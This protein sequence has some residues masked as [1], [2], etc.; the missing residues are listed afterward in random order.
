MAAPNNH[1]GTIAGTAGGTLLSLFASVH[2]EDIVKTVVL[3]LVGAI[4]SFAVSLGLKLLKL[5]SEKFVVL[6]EVDAT[7]GANELTGIR[8]TV[9]M[10]VVV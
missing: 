4:V 7:D 5:L 8:L 2:S 9:F 1:S 3:A 6:S 10:A